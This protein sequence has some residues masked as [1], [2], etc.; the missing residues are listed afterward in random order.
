MNY[1]VY[2]IKFEDGRFYI[3]SRQSK[4]PASKDVKY[5]GSP[6]TFKHL[7]E[8]TSLSKTKHILKVCDSFEEM[9]ELEPKLIKEAWKKYP[10]LCLNKNAAGSIHPDII[11][12]QLT[13]KEIK[14]R[15]I[16]GKKV[17]ELG[18]GVHSKSFKLRRKDIS[19]KVGK[20]NYILGRG[21]FSLTPEEKF[22]G[23]SKGGKKGGTSTFKLG[24]GIYRPDLQ[25]KWKE[26]S[27]KGG[28]ASAKK[29]KFISP[30]GKVYEGINYHQWCRD[31]GFKPSGFSKI[32]N[33]YRKTTY[34]GWRLG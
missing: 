4:V 1:Y 23:S 24:K 19:S 21:I 6:V 28:R 18:L 5:W 34:G 27:A 9:N 16:N 33:G 15:S 2:M 8:D 26:W 7:W 25:H 13:E 10:D 11:H 22:N 3:G 12:R 20:M 29:F 14:E 31:M 30:E 32:F 17:F